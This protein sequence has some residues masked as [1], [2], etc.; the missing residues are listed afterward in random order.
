MILALVLASATAAAD[1]GQGTW[2][3]TEAGASLWHAAWAGQSGDRFGH[4]GIDGAGLRIRAGALFGIAP[5]F[6]L[7]PVAGGDMA[8]TRASS[9]LCCGEVHRVDTARIGVEGSYWPDPR[10][11]FRVLFGFGLAAAATRVDDEGRKNPG[12][13][14]PSYPTGSYFTVG[15]ARDTRI[16]P[17]TRIGGAL[18]L[19]ADRLTTDA[20][21]MRTLLPSLS[22][23][24]LTQ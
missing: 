19:E 5:G 1:P 2:I 24:L 8:F 23:V 20:Q 14:G 15:I 18:R 7:G 16:G 22:L 9:D 21:S 17:N 4:G 6:A 12:I 3:V 13:L 11:G 10:F